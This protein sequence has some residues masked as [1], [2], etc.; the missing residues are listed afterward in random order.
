MNSYSYKA[1]DA[2]GDLIRGV[3]EADNTSSVHE[4]LTTRGLYVLYVK[5]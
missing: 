1:L 4:N 5:E 3:L 2:K